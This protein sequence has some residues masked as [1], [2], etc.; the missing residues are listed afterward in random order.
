MKHMNKFKT[1]C[2]KFSENNKGCN[3]PLKIF[4]LILDNSKVYCYN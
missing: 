1:S 4:K 3:N 2:T